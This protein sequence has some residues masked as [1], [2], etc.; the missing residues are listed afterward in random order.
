MNLLGKL[1]EENTFS[2]R[3]TN[4]LNNPTWSISPRMFASTLAFVFD[5][6]PKGI[7]CNFC[8]SL[9]VY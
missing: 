8:V 9:S 2:Y 3:D 1:G 7:H 4:F 6:V 5:Q